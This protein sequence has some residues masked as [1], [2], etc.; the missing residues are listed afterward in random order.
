MNIKFILTKAQVLLDDPSTCVRDIHNLKL[1][2]ILLYFL[3][4]K[5]KKPLISI[6][7]T[8]YKKKNFLKK[9]FNLFESI[10]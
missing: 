8:Y 7:I 5:M 4:K 3:C 1:K 9:L 2:K 10:L 6:V